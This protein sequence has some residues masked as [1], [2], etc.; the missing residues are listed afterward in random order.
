M[1]TLWLAYIIKKHNHSTD[2][3]TMYSS[4]NKP[5]AVHLVSRPKAC[6]PVGYHLAAAFEYKEPAYLFIIELHRDGLRMLTLR[7]FA[8]DRAVEFLRTICHP[9]LINAAIRRL[10]YII[11]RAETLRYDPLFHNCEHF[12]RYV[13]LGKQESIQ[14]KTIAGFGILAGAGLFALL[15]SE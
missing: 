12:A 1:I 2:R 11:D 13:V 5:I 7:D 10:N 8:N 3:I 14:V 4:Y 6:I 9:R 15:N